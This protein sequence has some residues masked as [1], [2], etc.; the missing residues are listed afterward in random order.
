[1]AL[2]D[3]QTSADLAAQPI[4][5][6]LAGPASDEV[7]D[8]IDRLRS[9]VRVLAEQDFPPALRQRL[10]TQIHERADDIIDGAFANLRRTRLPLSSRVRALVHRL[11]DALWTMSGLYLHETSPGE[12][13]IKGL[14]RPQELS[15]WLALDCIRKH[16]LLS[17]VVAALP[18]PDVWRTAHE[19]RMRAVRGGLLD[20]LPPGR[21]ST[22]AEAYARTLLLG[23]APPASFSGAEWCFIDAYLGERAPHLTLTESRPVDEVGCYWINVDS[24]VPPTAL[25]RKPPALGSKCLYFSTATVADELPRSLVAGEGPGRTAIAKLAGDLPA[26][27]ALTALARLHEILVEPRKRRFSRR[28]QGY[29]A[30]LCFR[31]DAI[32]Q[33]LRGERDDG[34]LGEWQ[35][36]N[37]SPDGYATMHVTGKTQ[38]LQVGDLAAIRRYHDDEWQICVVRWALSEN[39]EHFEVG[40]QAIAPGATAGLL[41]LPGPLQLNKQPVLLLAPVGDYRGGMMAVPTGLTLVPDANLVVLTEGKNI[42]VMELRIDRMLESTAGADLYLLTANTRR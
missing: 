25:L 28:R 8:D 21:A 9:Y 40:L 34:E 22:V 20:A 19:L 27:A 41:A 42:G 14:Q 39:P 10:T 3:S 15:I 33:L 23:C 38:K 11:Q 4:V 24:D 29:R 35:V 5:A 13:L 2:P 1:M 32:W 16:L 12:R 30:R 36:V 17:N 37:E 6:W 26:S 31:L 7:D 18:A